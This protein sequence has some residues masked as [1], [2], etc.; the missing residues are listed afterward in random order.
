MADLDALEESARTLL[1]P[2]GGKEQKPDKIKV[3]KST[4]E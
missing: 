1:R 2:T 3:N 4:E